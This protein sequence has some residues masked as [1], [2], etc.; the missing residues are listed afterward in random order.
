MAPLSTWATYATE[1]Q[2]SGIVRVTVC[3]ERPCLSLTCI[4]TRE[5]D[6]EADAGTASVCADGIGVVVAVVVEGATC[7]LGDLTIVGRCWCR[8]D[9]GKESQ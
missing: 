8:E 7:A 4:Y 1:F 3:P 6:V 5:V 9:K 2:L